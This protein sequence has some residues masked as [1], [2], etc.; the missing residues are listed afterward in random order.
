MASSLY[1]INK[2]SK[3]DN[4]DYESND[5]KQPDKDIQSVI[6]SFI[7]KIGTTL[8]SVVNRKSNRQNANQ[9]ID[10]FAKYLNAFIKS[11]KVDLSIIA[12]SLPAF[13]KYHIMQFRAKASH[14][15]KSALAK[16]ISNSQVK[17]MKC[18]LIG[19]VLLIIYHHTCLDNK[20]NV[21]S[22]PRFNNFTQRKQQCIK[23]LDLLDLLL[24][25]G[26]NPSIDP[27]P[28]HSN[29]DR[30]NWALMNTYDKWKTE[31]SNQS[32]PYQ[33]ETSKDEYCYGFR[34]IHHLA[35]SMRPMFTTELSSLLFQKQLKLKL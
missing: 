28:V 21:I 8:S 6:K 20:R 13:N 30:L 7:D 23:C 15:D 12:H 25:C 11:S 17:T 32:K 27:F 16:L 19:A 22:S 35:S 14:R 2:R 1:K 18:N 5:A 10:K 33:I 24:Q 31:K 29:Y 9:Q 26:V 34:T 3:D 4:S